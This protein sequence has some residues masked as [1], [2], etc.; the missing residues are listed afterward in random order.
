MILNFNSH[1]HTPWKGKKNSIIFRDLLLI[2]PKQFNLMKM[3]KSL[4]WF[5]KMPYFCLICLLD[6]YKIEM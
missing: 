6:L 4:L 5:C 3:N 1:F 2:Y